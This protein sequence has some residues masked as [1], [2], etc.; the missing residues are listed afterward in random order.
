MEAAKDPDDPRLFALVGELSVQDPEFRKL[1][2]EQH[3][4]S[5]G[6][7]TRIF[8][9]PAAGVLGL[10]WDILVSLADPYQELVVWTAEPDSPAHEGLRRLKE[11]ANAL[12]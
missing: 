2:A 10:D 4:A 7:G 8:H 1:W 12:V 5:K 3:V 6:S 9:H 11:L